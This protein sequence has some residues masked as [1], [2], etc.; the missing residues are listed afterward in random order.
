[1][2]PLLTATGVGNPSFHVHY[3]ELLNKLMLSLGYSEYVTQGGDWGH[4]LTRVLASQYGPQHVKASHT[5]F[6]L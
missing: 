3:A 5:N 2:L 4:T 6:P 1:M